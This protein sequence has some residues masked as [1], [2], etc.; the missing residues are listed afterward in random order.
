[1]DTTTKIPSPTDTTIPKE[2]PNNIPAVAKPNG[3]ATAEAE[4]RM[5]APAPASITGCPKLT[6]AIASVMAEVQAIAKGGTNSF[7]R[8]Q[9]A[10][11]QDILQTL[12]P[13]IGKHGLVIFQTER[14]RSVFDGGNVIAIQYQFTIT[15]SSG[16][17]WPERPLQTGMSRCRN[18]KDGFD[19]KSLA[20]CHTAAR[21]YFLLAL[22]Q[23]PTA[24][25]TDDSDRS[26]RNRQAPPVPSPSG[27]VPPHTIEPVRGETAKS[28]AAK[29]E[30]AIKTS[31]SK[32]ELDQWDSL[33]DALLE[34]L[35]ADAPKIYEAI[36]Q[37]VDTLTK[38]FDPSSSP[39]NAAKAT[40][41]TP[42]KEGAPASDGD[43]EAF[44]GW[45][46][47]HME[48]AT[49]ADHVDQ[50]FN[51]D[52]EPFWGS[53]FP[54]DQDEILAAHKRIRDKFDA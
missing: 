21:K 48:T 15:H 1:M 20:K 45:A 28:W 17:V 22:F 13:L 3:F 16:E 54:P 14:E 24:D 46:K 51:E 47:Q 26:A 12:T 18:A 43:P 4:G 38:G 7:H 5:D 40:S 25:E 31:R 19:D 6:A 11:M 49:S 42:A 29:Y 34:K 33:N 37:L 36:L 50:I 8:Y 32:A 53:L 2:A 9:Y 44:I 10:R 23:V 52:I 39:P 30:T 41:R 35:D 27:H